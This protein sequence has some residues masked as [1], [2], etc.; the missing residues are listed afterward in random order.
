[1]SPA[2]TPACDAAWWQQ[3]SDAAL[4]ALETSAGG[5][6]A[7]EAG[8]RLVRWGA[9]RLAPPPRW[10]MLAQI[11]RR[12]RDPLVL[13]LLVA[14]GLSL[15]SGEPA[16]AGIIAVV[17]LVSIALDQFQQ[18]RAESAAARLRDSVAVR[19]CV[20]RDGRE[21][22]V[23]VAQ[24]VPGDI[25]HLAAGD[26]VPGDGLLLHAQD[27]FVRESTLTGESF[28]VEKSLSAPTGP[29]P[30]QNPSAVFMGSS[31]VS[32]LGTMLVC[33]TGTATQIGGISDALIGA[34]EDLAFE[35]DLRQ[36]GSFILRITLSLV[37][38]VLLVSGLARRPWLDSFL[39]AVA[40]AVGLTPE[41]LPMVVTISLSR[42][43]LRLARE[44]VIVKRLAAVHNLGAIDVLCTDKTGTL[45]EARIELIRHVDA[46][47]RD[48]EAVIEAAYLN[49]FFESGIHTPLE[50]AILA[51]GG[52]DAA[53]WRKIDEVPFD[54]ERRRLSVLVAHGGDRRLIVKGA[55]DDVL[56]HCDRWLDRDV[57]RP[58]TPSAREAAAATLQQLESEGFRVLGLASKQVPAS[59]QDARLGDED[60]L[61]FVGYAAF[62]DPPK[63]DAHAAIADLLAKGV[64][65]KVVT[66]DSELVTQHVCHALGMRVKGVLLGR[67]IEALD[68]RALARRVGRANLFCRVTPMQKE[69]VIRAL[70]ARGHVVGY[71]GDGVNDAPALHAADVGISVDGAADTARA[72]ADLILLRHSLAVLSAA[73]TEGRRTF[74]NTRKY[75]LLGTSSNFGNMASMAA[76]AVLLP[77][78]PMLPVQILLNNLLYDGVS[79]ALPLDRVEP[80]ETL[81]PQPW[82]MG[83]LRRFM[84][85]FGPVSS[86]FDLATFALLLYGLGASVDQ[87][88]SGW[89]IESLATQVLAVFVI[90][91]RGSALAGRP[92]AALQAAAGG[93]L[94]FAAV[95]PWTPLGAMFGLVPL[96]AVAYAALAAMTLGY[97]V[98][99]EAVKRRFWRS[100]EARPPVTSRRRAPSRPAP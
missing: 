79:A 98:V 60:E 5:L 78:L 35:R 95:L 77:F 48:S 42:G 58:W 24:L 74:S 19:A 26:L 55:P 41:L 69:R 9:N 8:E 72:A 25:V 49:S 68:D 70:R 32:G 45:T 15:V 80:E 67:D 6:T 89:F 65:V 20:L 36:F 18:R 43:A 84:F 96:P 71:L 56:R 27:L 29:A 38:L 17:I 31:V 57:A 59:Q 47:G 81:A 12:L 23:G 75:L 52:A 97:L 37:L 53:G 92:H 61:V 21:Q 34:R 30:E 64:Q 46:G 1:M 100:Q 82:D 90:R 91:T 2:A 33:R 22:E 39:F 28:P 7:A 76:A 44:Q 10:A 87:F 4:A 88:R 50:D 62:L 93:V 51:H 16:S 83:Q 66:G 73:V 11:A 54:F 3:S 13:V 85:T 99:L 94:A 14:G 40:L 63:A 86:L